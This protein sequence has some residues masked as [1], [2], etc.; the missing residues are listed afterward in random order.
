MDF[1]PTYIHKSNI[2]RT[3]LFFHSDDI[4]L[5]LGTE[6]MHK[7]LLMFSVMSSTRRLSVELLIQK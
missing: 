7:I 2:R 6:G 1:F 4:S 5:N 3:F